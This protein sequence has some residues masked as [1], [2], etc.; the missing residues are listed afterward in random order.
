MKPDK[1]QS[2]AAREN[3]TRELLSS[4][5]LLRARRF[6]TFWSASLLSNI[7]TWGAAG[8]GAVAAAAPGASPFLAAF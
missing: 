8:R 6:G 3:P 5:R 2:I 4:L 7:G 1:G